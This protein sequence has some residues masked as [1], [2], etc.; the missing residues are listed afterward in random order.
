MWRVSFSLQRF[1][2]VEVLSVPHFEQLLLVCFGPFSDELPAPLGNPTFHYVQ[3]LQLH[4]RQMLAILDV[5]V[6]RW[7]LLVY[8]E[9]PDDNSVETA[10]LRH[11]AVVSS[12]LSSPNVKPGPPPVSAPERSD[13]PAT[14]GRAEALVGRL[15]GL[16]N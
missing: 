11:G 6:P 7:M 15:F 16:T 3:I 13:G 4:H 1:N 10:N 9:H 8:E 2:V 12:A 14:G 5:D